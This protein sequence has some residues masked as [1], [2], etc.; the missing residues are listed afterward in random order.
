MGG[1]PVGRSVVRVFNGVKQ[2]RKDAVGKDCCKCHMH[3]YICRLDLRRI[4]FTS[5]YFNSFTVA[6]MFGI[7]G[8][9]RNE[10][11]PNEMKAKNLPKTFTKTT[12]RHDFNY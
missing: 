8:S 12:S 7:I 10:T 4:H 5:Q 1:R 9:Q 11:K 2:Q 3:A 6:C